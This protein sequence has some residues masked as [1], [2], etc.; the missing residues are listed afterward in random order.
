LDD[1]VN[2]YEKIKNYDDIKKLI[3]KTNTLLEEAEKKVTTTEKITELAMRYQLSRAFIP[4]I[5]EII[6]G[7]FVLLDESAQFKEIASNIDTYTE[8]KIIDYCEILKTNKMNWPKIGKL[9]SDSLKIID[10]E[11]VSSYRKKHK[12]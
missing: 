2:E 12:N 7:M 4:E 5:G 8:E 9:L 3:H 6:D 11:Q 1:F 10:E